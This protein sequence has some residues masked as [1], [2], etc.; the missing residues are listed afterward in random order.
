MS[1]KLNMQISIY[2]SVAVKEDTTLCVSLTGACLHTAV[3]SFDSVFRESVFTLVHSWYLL[4]V[5]K[6]SLTADVLGETPR[7]NTLA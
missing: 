2:L 5:S 6:P 3:V 4:L 1:I 7:E